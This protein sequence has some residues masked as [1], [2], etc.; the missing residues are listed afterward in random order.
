[1]EIKKLV[2]DEGKVQ[3]TVACPVCNESVRMSVVKNHITKQAML[4]PFYQKVGEIENTP[5]FDFWKENTFKL[6]DRNLWSLEFED[7]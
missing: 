2:L 3:G 7:F 4:E 6:K 5:H 1:M